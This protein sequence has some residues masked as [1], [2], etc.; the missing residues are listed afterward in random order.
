MGA[1]GTI[2]KQALMPGSVMLLLLGTVAGALL[3][4]FA[5]TREMGRRWLIALAAL[6]WALSTPI[7]ADGLAGLVGYGFGPLQ[8]RPDAS[9]VVVLDGGSAHYDLGGT[10]ID[11]PAEPTLFRALEAARVYRLLDGPQAPLVI[12]TGGSFFAAEAPRQGAALV[13]ALVQGGVPPTHVY[14]DNTS[15][16]TREHALNIGRLLRERGIS[17]FV[18]V[19]SKT[20]M[21]RSLL[22]FEHEGLSPVPS[23]AP[24]RAQ[25]PSAWVRRWLPEVDSLQVSEQAIYDMLGLGYYWVRGWT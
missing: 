16:N 10:S 2:L 25:A 18:L 11:V 6:Y 23:A 20:H 3:L 21:R 13:S 19:T 4:L 12:A 9:A 1:A 14:L 8:A 5:R 15:R 22:S 17:R 7:I 24:L